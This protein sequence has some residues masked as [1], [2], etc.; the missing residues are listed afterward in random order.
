MR[1]TLLEPKL[2]NLLNTKLDEIFPT[3]SV[4]LSQKDKKWIDA[5]LKKLDRLKKREWGKNGKS[6]K[7]LELKN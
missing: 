6:P 7:Y 4:K 5:N 2:Q 3:K 1:V